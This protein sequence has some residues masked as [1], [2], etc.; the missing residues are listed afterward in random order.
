[1]MAKYAS[2]CLGTSQGPN[3]RIA[4]VYAPTNEGEDEAEDTFCDQL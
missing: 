1:M 4:Q 3:H 2:R